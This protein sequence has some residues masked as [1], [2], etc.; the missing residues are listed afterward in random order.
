MAG[1]LNYL[2]N[3]FVTKPQTM[4]RAEGKA[5]NRMSSQLVLNNTEVREA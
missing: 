2:I 4:I 1:N 3:K 5:I